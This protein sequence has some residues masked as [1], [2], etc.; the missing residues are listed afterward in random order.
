LESGLPI[1]VILDSGNKSIHAWVR[2]DAEESIVSPRQS[3]SAQDR[4]ELEARASF[5]G[6]PGG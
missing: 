3:E 4:L 6:W 5:G 2:V 1:S